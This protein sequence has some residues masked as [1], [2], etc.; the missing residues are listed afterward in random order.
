MLDVDFVLAYVPE[1]NVLSWEAAEQIAIARDEW[2]A[3]DLLDSIHDN[4][5]ANVVPLC[6][7]G[8]HFYWSV[9]GVTY[10]VRCMCG[11]VQHG[12]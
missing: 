7:D 11:E 8:V 4:E 6:G 10:P 1:A 9:V 3:K 5:T 12:E 2:A